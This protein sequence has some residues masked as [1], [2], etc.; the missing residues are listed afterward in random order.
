MGAGRTQQHPTE[1]ISLPG[2]QTRAGRVDVHGAQVR[3][4]QGD[5]V[6]P[7]LA[8]FLAKLVPASVVGKIGAAAVTVAVVAGGGT[9]ALAA[10]SSPDTTTVSN[11][12]EV[13]SPAPTE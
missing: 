3:C 13:T 1:W 10:S 12:I 8:A 2:L 6:S 4:V 11:D 5:I 9:A 7:F